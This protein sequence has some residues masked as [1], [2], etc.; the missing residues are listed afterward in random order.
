[1]DTVPC[2]LHLRRPAE[3]GRPTSTRCGAEGKRPSLRGRVFVLARLHGE[4]ALTLLKGGQRPCGV[5]VG[6]LRLP[7]VAFLRPSLTACRYH[8][9]L[10][11]YSSTPSAPPLVRPM[12]MASAVR[13]V[14]VDCRVRGGS[15]SCVWRGG[16]ALRLTHC[17]CS[18]SFPFLPVRP[19]PRS[20]SAGRDN[21]TSP[22]RRA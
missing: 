14:C 7:T 3:A 8:G 2:K 15:G 11:E 6:D 17:C 9:P 22:S 13:G 5:C 20:T 10:V 19:S 12:A 18:R 1:M 4:R 21:G 16:R